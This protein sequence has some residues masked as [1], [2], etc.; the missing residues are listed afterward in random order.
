MLFEAVQTDQRGLF[1]FG[2]VRVD[3]NAFSNNAVAKCASL[4]VDKTLFVNESFENR[5]LHFMPSALG[6]LGSL[7]LVGLVGVGGRVA[8]LH[9]R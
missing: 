7:V 1:V 6:V 5:L 4:G 8:F 9:G 3:F 2:R